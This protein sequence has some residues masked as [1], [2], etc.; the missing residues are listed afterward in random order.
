VNKIYKPHNDGINKNW[1]IQGY[2]I[3]NKAGYTNLEIYL[4]ELAGDFHILVNK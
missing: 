2:S 3:K 1:E 4:A